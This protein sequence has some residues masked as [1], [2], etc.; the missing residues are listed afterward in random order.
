MLNSL[1]KFIG[2]GLGSGLSPVAPGTAGSLAAV[3]IYYLVALVAGG[4]TPYILAVLILVGA[5]LGI[6]ATG[7]LVTD[8]APDPG[9]AVWDEFVGMWITCL[10]L[11]ATIPWLAAAFF[12]FRV[13]DIFKPW[14]ANRLESWRGGWGIMADDVVAGLYGAV[15]LNAAQLTW[16]HFQPV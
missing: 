3:V 9:R 8:A 1:G 14:P 16:Q 6:W 5:P 7:L 2:L 15:L 12:T 11:P 10:F 13:F 4:A